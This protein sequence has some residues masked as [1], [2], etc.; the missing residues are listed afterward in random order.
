MV[1]LFCNIQIT[2]D[3]ASNINRR[4]FQ[5]NWLI[6]FIYHIEMNYSNCQTHNELMS[7]SLFTVQCPPQPW[8]RGRQRALWK[9]QTLL[10][11]LWVCPAHTLPTSP[12]RAQTSWLGNQ[13]TP[14]QTAIR[15]TSNDFM[16]SRQFMVRDWSLVIGW[17]RQETAM[18]FVKSYWLPSTVHTIHQGYFKYITHLMLLVQTD[19]GWN[20]TS[21]K[22]ELYGGTSPNKMRILKRRKMLL[23]N[24]LDYQVCLL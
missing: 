13:Y 17:P 18:T 22:R 14:P 20:T 15:G 4:V 2:F 19:L 3:L 24:K 12:C 1:K 11:G 6:T 7:H 10:E 9:Y 8:W 23:R 5:F 21:W 16:S